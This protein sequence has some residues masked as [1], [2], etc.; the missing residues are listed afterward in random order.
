MSLPSLSLEGKVAIITGG[1]RGIGKAIAL[2]F[3][4]AGADV[5]VSSRVVKD[6]QDNLEAVAEEIR[7][8]GQRSLAI[9]ADVSRKS[10]I[11]NLVQR[12]LDEFGVIDILVNSASIG[13]GGSGKQDVPVL[14]NSEDTWDAVLDINLK[15]QYLCC[16]AVSK[17]MISKKV[18]ILSIYRR[19]K[20]SEGIL[21]IVFLRQG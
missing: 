1:K 16:Q 10:E 20:H 2:T 6:G 8:L 4:E 15:G 21:L 17:R 11:D 14:E 5:V 13:G 3:A 7:N 12:V 9:Q 18:A 19:R